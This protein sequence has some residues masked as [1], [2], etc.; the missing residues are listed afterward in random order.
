[1]LVI[2]V[3]ATGA[4]LIEC[5]QKVQS[6]KIGFCSEHHSAICSSTCMG[7][8]ARLLCAEVITS[9]RSFTAK[10]EVATGD[11][12]DFC[13]LFGDVLDGLGSASGSS[14]ASSAVVLFK[15]FVPEPSDFWLALPPP[16]KRRCSCAVKLRELCK[17]SIDCGHST[18]QA[19]HSKEL[20]GQQCESC[21]PLVCLKSLFQCDRQLNIGL[22]MSLAA[23]WR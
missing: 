22:P 16:R 11:F 20:Q 1:M 21:L 15:R 7:M 12:L 10:L 23:W 14:F 13:A 18:H 9:M 6:V 3:R 19:L 4:Q 17:L 5:P 2:D 8:Q